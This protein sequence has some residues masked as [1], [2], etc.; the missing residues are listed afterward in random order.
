CTHFYPSVECKLP[1]DRNCFVFTSLALRT[2]L[3]QKV[4]ELSLSMQILA[5][6][7]CHTDHHAISGVLYTPFPVILGHEATGIVESIGEG[8]TTVKPGDKVIPFCIS[9]CGKCSSCINPNGNF[10]MEMMLKNTADKGVLSGGTTRFTCKGKPIYH[11]LNISSFA[12]YTVT[13][14]FLVTK[15]DA[16]APPEKVFL[17]GCGFSTGYGAAINAAKVRKDV[18]PGSTCAVFGLGGNA[19][20]SRIIGIDINPLKFERAK[21]ARAPECISPKDYTKPISKVLNDMTDNSVGYTGFEAVGHLETVTSVI[22]GFPPPP[23]MLTYDPML[24]FTGYTWKG[25]VFGDIFSRDEIMKL[26]TKMTSQNYDFMAKIFDLDQLIIHVLPL[27]KIKEEFYLLHKGE[28]YVFY[29]F[30]ISKNTICI[31]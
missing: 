22:V 28:M 15:I 20:A 8:V 12:E 25:R 13:S 14:E 3:P 5:T 7:I 2:V 26:T 29:M 1:E 9:Q 30:I 4:S 17:I 23:K 19:G 10:C 18:T 21:A 27:N 31:I 11:F 6:G 24:L 16:A